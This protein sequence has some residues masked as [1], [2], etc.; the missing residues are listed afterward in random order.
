MPA[1]P[2]QPSAAST[3]AP[4]RRAECHEPDSPATLIWNAPLRDP[5]GYAGGPNLYGFVPRPCPR[6]SRP[7]RGTASAPSNGA[8]G[9]W[10]P[11]PAARG[12]LCRSAVACCLPRC[13]AQADPLE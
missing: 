1:T 10:E 11:D 3:L 8:P 4:P 5:S 13:E 7:P 2:V 12:L 6:E 9:R